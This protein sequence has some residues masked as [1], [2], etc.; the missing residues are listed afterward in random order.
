MN[1]QSASNLLLS[2]IQYDVT[3][4]RLGRWRRYIY[5][6]GQLFEEFV[7]HGQVFN[8]PLLHF[9]R[10]RCPE[11]GRRIIAKGLIA[12]GRMAFGIVAIGQASC[13]VIAVGQLSI[14]VFLAL[15]QAAIGLFALG[16][17]ALATSFGIG[18]FATGYAAI[19]QFAYGK[20]VL[21]QI[22][23]GEFV[24]DTRHASKEAVQFFKAFLP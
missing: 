16:Q 5:P 20:Y 10:G 22:G 17:V 13:G 4:T 18:Q 11:T 9:T 2:D 7:S 12:I 1:S 14:G 3:E 19:G 23:K 8:M 24:W 21:A 15:G 6:T